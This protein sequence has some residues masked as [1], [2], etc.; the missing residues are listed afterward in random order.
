MPG[1]L[2]TSGSRPHGSPSLIVH[3][4]RAEG[5]QQ[6]RPHS[7]V[8][9]WPVQDKE[10]TFKEL[11]VLG[12][13]AEEA[14]DIARAALGQW[15]V[16]Q[17]VSTIMLVQ[18]APKAHCSVERLL[19]ALHLSKAD[20]EVQGGILHYQLLTHRG[21]WECS[22]AG[23]VDPAPPSHTL[24]IRWRR[25]A[26]DEGEQDD[27]DMLVDSGEGDGVCADDADPPPPFAG[28]LPRGGGRFK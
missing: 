13:T 16:V 6:L 17:A 24:R 14:R 26:D 3:P 2:C 19:R 9:E 4:F 18:S 27:Q 7:V 20:L 21:L 15:E 1:Y 28:P 25:A 10:A 5:S 22:T 12:V 23:E 11:L 8:S